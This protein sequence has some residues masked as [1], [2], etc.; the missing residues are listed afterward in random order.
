MGLGFRVWGLGLRV[1]EFGLNFGLG[2]RVFRVYRSK[3]SQSDPAFG[4]RDMRGF[5]ISAFWVRSRGLLTSF[6][7][8]PAK[9]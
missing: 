7:L 8:I 9:P 3:R 2:L 4:L 5:G 6:K 1:W